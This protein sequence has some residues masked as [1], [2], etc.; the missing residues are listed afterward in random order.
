MDFRELIGSGEV[1]LE[2]V[3]YYLVKFTVYEEAKFAYRSLTLAGFN[4]SAITGSVHEY[5]I[6]IWKEV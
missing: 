4:T 6:Y 2:N 5:Y 3:H 1:V